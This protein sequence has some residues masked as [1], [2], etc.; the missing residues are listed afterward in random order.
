VYLGTAFVSRSQKKLPLV[1]DSIPNWT[2]A[3]APKKNTIL[4]ASILDDPNI[5]FISSWFFFELF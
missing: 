4:F 2:L 5:I 1:I 3:S